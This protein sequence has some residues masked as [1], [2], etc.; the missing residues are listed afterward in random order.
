MSDIAGTRYPLAMRW[1]AAILVLAICASLGAAC[2]DGPDGPV[3]TPSPEGPS[4]PVQGLPVLG[5]AMQSLELLGIVEG[6]MT[7][8]D[9]SC[10][11]LRDPAGGPGRFQAALQG[12]VSG[13]RHTI[14]FVVHGYIGPGEYSWDGVPGSGPEVTIELDGRERGHA[15]IFIDD[16]GAGE[17]DGIFSS[18]NQGRIHGVFECPGVPR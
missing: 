2:G 13:Q 14:R 15:T 5:P 6:V 1:T 8:S 11:W 18:P 12:M 4:A 3:S 17:I 10:A 16:F 9:A 7:E